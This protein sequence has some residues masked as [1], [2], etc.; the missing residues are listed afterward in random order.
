M[1]KNRM[2]LGIATMVITIIMIANSIS[3][4]E[5]KATT[6]EE[7]IILTEKLY[8]ADHYIEGIEIYPLRNT[9]VGVN[10][11]FVGGSTEFPFDVTSYSNLQGMSLIVSNQRLWRQFSQR[12]FWD[13]ADG[14]TLVTVFRG[15]DLS[16]AV[17][18]GRKIKEMVETAYNFSL[19][20]V[21]A[22]WNNLEQ[23]TVL[24]YQGRVPQQVFEDFTDTFVGYVSNDGFGEG[25][26]TDVLNEAPI[27]AMGLGILH[28]RMEDFGTRIEWIPV[29]DVAW[30]NPEGLVRDETV[31]DMNLTNIMPDLAHIQ[32]AADAFASVVS[33]KLPY[34]VNVLEIDPKPDNMYPHLKGNFEWVVKF[35]IPIF[36]V[37]RTY[38]DIYVSYDLNITSLRHF[39]QVIGELSLNN[40]LPIDGTQD[41]EYIFTFENVGDEVANDITLAYGEFN[42]A[43]L[44]GTILPIQNPDLDYDDSKTMW[45]DK[46]S[47]LVSSTVLPGDVVIIDGWFQNNSD[48][49][50]LGD[51]EYYPGSNF[52]TLLSYAYVNETFLELDYGDFTENN[53]TEDGEKFSLNTTINSLAPGE[54][55]TKSFAVRNLPT[56]T[57]NLF[58]GKEIA[59]DHWEL[60]INTT[61]DWEVYF[62]HLLRLMGSTLHIPEDQVTYTNWFP[63]EIMGSAFVYYDDNG[64][65]F[66]GITNG[67]VIQVYD[68]EAVLVGKVSLDKDVYRFGEE[69]T[70]TLELENIGNANA[71]NINY[72]FYHAFVTDELA[73]GYIE[74]IRGSNG[75]IDLIKPGETEIKQFTI[76]ATTHVGLHPVF[77]IFGYTSDEPGEDP[78]DDWHNLPDIIQEQTPEWFLN[79]TYANSIFNTTTHRK[80]VSSMD[81]GMV[82]PPVNKEGTTK[83]IYPTPEVDIIT[84]IIGLTNET[85]IGD[86]IKLRTTITNVGDEDT[87]I[88]YI[89]RLPQ[90]Q[91]VP[92]SDQNDINI[93]VEGVQI[94]DFEAV[95][96]RAPTYGMAVGIIAQ[97]INQE[98]AFGIPLAVNETMVIEIVLEVTG[99]GEVFIPPTEVRYRSEF[100]MTETRSIQED[101][102][103]TDSVIATELT[104]SSMLGSLSRQTL[105][106]DT[107]PPTGGDVS[108]NSW[109][110]YSE[111]LSIVI[112]ELGG[113][114]FKYI[115]IGVGLIAVTGVAVLIYF[116]AN[117]KKH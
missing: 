39:P 45:Y 99:S 114:G 32:G 64:K 46:T 31:I 66:M 111:S 21:V 86:E 49:S 79:L 25:I 74:R 14:A 115:Y 2:I 106:F 80:I 17:D 41:L 73:L 54:N 60:Y 85:T 55:I 6:I 13:V 102:E 57:L 40:S 27:K 94:T 37:D 104:A 88:I 29:L 38:E 8:E 12:R 117:G 67:L 96:D 24:I 11:G 50:W 105:E 98:G 9:S 43:D 100:N 76:P 72:D 26:T 56:G 51:G 101:T 18:D 4:A 70:F 59:T 52:D 92:S 109:G 89:Q 90:G 110:S 68:D 95:L 93:T 22:D 82:L 42:R 107:E 23:K 83:P 112:E 108:T 47:G 87:N 84:E 1:K 3:T 16:D 69:T 116:R 15:Q 20:L 81:F 34:V 10:V 58:D 35:D 28:G 53:L 19:T 44:N 103:R 48:G 78:R 75:T 91:L 36:G 30:V 71:T 113:L 63:Q 5:L 65:E 33:M 77:A 62:T 97:D 7:K 61:I